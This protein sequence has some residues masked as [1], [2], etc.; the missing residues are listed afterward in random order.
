MLLMAFLIIA[1]S[2]LCYLKHPMKQLQN[3]QK[4]RKFLLSRFRFDQWNS[5]YKFDLL[6]T[7]TTEF[8]ADI[9]IIC[10]EN[11]SRRSACS[12]PAGGGTLYLGHIKSRCW[13][14]IDALKVR[15]GSMEK[16]Q[17]KITLHW[18]WKCMLLCLEYSRELFFRNMKVLI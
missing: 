11:P 6:C 4:S 3:N 5:W 10:S 16:S 7:L 13:N 15:I 9:I 14:K 12:C 8:M 17:K 18:F 1:P 2:C